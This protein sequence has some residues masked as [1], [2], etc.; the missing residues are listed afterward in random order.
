VLV[1]VDQQAGLAFAVQSIDRQ[2]LVNNS[3]ALAKTAAAFSLPVIAST[4]ASKVYSGPM[5]EQLRLALPA[6][7]PMERRNM[8]LWED[9]ACR[10]AVL[11][12]GRR[13]MLVSGMLTEACVAFLAL[14]AIED[15]MEVYVVGDACGGASHDGHELALRRMAARGAVLT[16]WLQVLLELQRD[17]TRHDTYEAARAVVELNGGGYGL[18]LNYSRTM[19]A[20]STAP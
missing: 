9:Q 20:P 10:E 8:N 3:V 13:K 16:S 14:S 4:S 7:T 15:G 1:F 6:V 12:T 2:A 18:G 11:A 19:V 17:W 5:I